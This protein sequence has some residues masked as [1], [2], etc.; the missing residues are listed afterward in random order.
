LKAV[1]VRRH[2]GPEV[3]EYADAPDPAPAA[4]EVLV[5]IRAIGINRRDA[6]IRSGLYPRDLPL[7]PGIEASGVVAAP[8][9]GVTGWS[10][11]ERVIWY[12]PDRLGAYAEYMVVPAERLVRLPDALSFEDAAAVFDHGLTA[13]YLTTDTFALGP[14]H[15]ALVHAAAGGVASL[16]LQCAK[17]AGATVFGTVSTPEKA[18]MVAGLGADAAINHRDADVVGTVMELTGGR[19]VDVV[20]DSVGQDTIESS[21][22]CT[23]KRGMLVL[24]GAAGGPVR[25]IDPAALA[26]RGSLFFTRP[27]LFDHISTR[28]E[29]DRRSRDIFAWF[30]AGEIAAHVDAVFPLKEVAEAHRRLEDRSRWGKILLTP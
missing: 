26:D 28:D 24:Y 9:E 3:L 17:R 18:A 22:A 11:G 15:T 4:G 25:S 16:L 19:G 21:I 5:A 29:L 30:M 1:I 27:H 7:I 2:G 8:G 20:Y 10:P 12:V 6:F 14:G 23:A 13:H